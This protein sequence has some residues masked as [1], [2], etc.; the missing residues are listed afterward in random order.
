MCLRHAVW[1]GARTAR[2]R[3]ISTQGENA[4]TSAKIALLA[5][6]A[7]FAPGLTTTPAGAARTTGHAL[8]KP[9]D[10][11]GPSKAA[12]DAKKAPAAPTMGQALNTPVD[13]GEPSKELKD[14]ARNRP[15]PRRPWE[16]PCIRRSIRDRRRRNRPEAE[17][18][19]KD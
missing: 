7:I 9:A 11:R 13:V 15:L 8:D 12:Q 18:K 3:R 19:P 16:K 1:R 6:A 17:S 4:M 5:T 2:P 14:A 10:I